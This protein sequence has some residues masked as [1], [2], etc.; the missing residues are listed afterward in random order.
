MKKTLYNLLTIKKAQIWAVSRW[1]KAKA[2]VKAGEFRRG[3]GWPTF[4]Q[5]YATHHIMFSQTQKGFLTAFT[6]SERCVMLSKV[7]HQFAALLRRSYWSSGVKSDQEGKIWA[8]FDQCPVTVTCHQDYYELVPVVQTETDESFKCA[9]KYGY[10]N[11]SMTTEKPVDD[12]M[13]WSKAPETV[14]KWTEMRLFSEH[15]WLKSKG[16]KNLKFCVRVNALLGEAT[17]SRCV[18]QDPRKSCVKCEVL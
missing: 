15:L 1:N 4:L 2:E 14:A 3:W 7:R 9:G 16:K 17:M 6:Q 5:K 18:A 13:K 10:L 12:H 11:I 8:V